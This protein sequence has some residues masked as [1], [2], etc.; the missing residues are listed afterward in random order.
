VYRELLGLDDEEY[1]RLV[2][3]KIIVEDYLDRDMNPY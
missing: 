1:E 2:E 3:A